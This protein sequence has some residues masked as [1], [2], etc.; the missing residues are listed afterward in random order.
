MLT[1]VN[2]GLPSSGY[3]PDLWYA[4]LTWIATVYNIAGDRFLDAFDA[5]GPWEQFTFEQPPD[6]GF[7]NS[8]LPDWRLVKYPEY[9]VVIIQGSTTWDQIKRQIQPERQEEFA[10]GAGRV[11]P[12][13]QG[14]AGV[15]YAQM[16]AQIAA[17]SGPTRKIIV[18]GHS[19]G[20]ALAM[21]I[22]A[23]LRR[24]YPTTFKTAV[25]F[26]SPKVGD[27]AFADAYTVPCVNVQGTDDVV[28]L[29]PPNVLLSNL[30]IGAT[31]L[32]ASPLRRWEHAGTVYLIDPSGLVASYRTGFVFDTPDVAWVQTEGDE[33]A[34][35][36]Q[37]HYPQT[38]AKR[39]RRKIP[40]SFLRDNAPG[41]DFAKLDAA[42]VAMATARGFTLT[43]GDFAA[44]G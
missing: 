8:L 9:L 13:Y 40:D 32:F 18:L 10:L 44:A 34:F 41:W 5:A 14:A 6:V 43:L 11:S 37:L 23:M 7:E 28:T 35:D 17:Y 39:L 30:L 20:G 4:F 29:F 27:G 38:Y 19:Y 42:N 12:F 15:V 16:Q 22:A 36:F 2:L 24:D 3:R 26:G 21:F 33:A 1:T 25:V 31:D